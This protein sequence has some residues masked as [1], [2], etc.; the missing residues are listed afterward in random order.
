MRNEDNTIRVGERNC[1]V[2]SLNGSVLVC[3]PP[4]ANVSQTSD[5]QQKEGAALV[6]VIMFAILIL[7]KV[8]AVVSILVCHIRDWDSIPIYLKYLLGWS[9]MFNF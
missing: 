6:E 3:Q 1:R 4:T 9:E 7:H 8:G 2:S 5:E